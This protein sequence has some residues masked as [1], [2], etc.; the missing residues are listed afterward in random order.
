MDG[1]KPVFNV[2]Y[3]APTPEMRKAGIKVRGKKHR[4][5]IYRIAEAH[6]KNPKVCDDPVDRD[7]YIITFYAYPN[8]LDL[9]NKIYKAAIEVRECPFCGGEVELMYDHHCAGH[10]DFYK[11]AYMQCCNCGARSRGFVYNGY[12]GECTTELDAIEAWNSRVGGD[13]T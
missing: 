13:S 8:E 12:Y 11:T 9:M 2:V 6:D 3:R 5:T 10:G 4:D 1:R 7:C